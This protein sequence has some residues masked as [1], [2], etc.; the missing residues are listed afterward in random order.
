MRRRSRVISNV[1]GACRLIWLCGASH[2]E[3]LSAE[4]GLDT[5]NVDQVRNLAC[6]Y[7]LD[8]IDSRRDGDAHARPDPLFTSLL[9]GRK[10][11]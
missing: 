11:Y 8:L 5:Q 9:E 6:D 10:R 7:G 2:L 4:A 3:G 1:F